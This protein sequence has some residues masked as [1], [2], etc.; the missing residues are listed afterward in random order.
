MDGSTACHRLSRRFSWALSDV[1]DG[2]TGVD[3]AAHIIVAV[4]VVNSS[5]DIQQLPKVLDAI[6]AHT[7]QQVEQLL[8]E[9][10]YSRLAVMAELAQKLPQTDLVIG[11]GREAKQQSQPA[12]AQRLPHTL[13]MRAKLQTEQ[14]RATYRKCKWIAGPPNDWIKKSAGLQTLKHAETRKGE[15]QVQALLHGAE[16]HN[17]GRNRHMMRANTA[18]NPATRPQ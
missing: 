1:R 11:L 4:K 8:A 17:N 6:Q 7:G 14:G 3:E 16:S 18:S 9:A 5:S 2:Q 15:S 13:A 10:G 12:D